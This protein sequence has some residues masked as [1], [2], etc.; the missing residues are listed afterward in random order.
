MSIRTTTMG[1]LAL[2]A[3]L[4]L[5]AGVRAQTNQ[6]APGQGTQMQ[7]TEGQTKQISSQDRAWLEHMA[8]GS[9]AEIKLGALAQEKGESASVRQ[10]GARLEKDHRKFLD[11]AKPVA[12]NLSVTLKEQPT[13]QQKMTAERLQKLPKSSF[14]ADFA[15]GQV[16]DHQH[17]IQLTKAATRSDNPEVRSLA[18]KTLPVLQEHEKMAKD[19]M[20]SSK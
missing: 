4:L 1:G 18:E 19:A 17:D 11:D 5:P 8:Q 13:E 7:G 3:A 20:S 2:A 14:D 15:K 12:R 10:L 6:A 16:E 9:A